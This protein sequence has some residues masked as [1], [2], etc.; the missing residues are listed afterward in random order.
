MAYCV[1]FTILYNWWV[2]HDYL[3]VASDSFLYSMPPHT[4][5]NSTF[6]RKEF[7]KSSIKLRS[8]QWYWA[9]YA[10]IA[11]L[12]GPAFV[13]SFETKPDVFQYQNCIHCPTDSTDHSEVLLDG[14]ENPAPRHNCETDLNLGYKAWFYNVWQNIRTRSYDVACALWIVLNWKRLEHFITPG[15]N[16]LPDTVSQTVYW[17][18]RIYVP[19]YGTSSFRE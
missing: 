12:Y 1:S 13:W 4:P 17:E 11:V 14:K 18:T 9:N 2:R 6:P 19:I 7:L 8:L 10:S 5:K 15:S 3:Y 16:S